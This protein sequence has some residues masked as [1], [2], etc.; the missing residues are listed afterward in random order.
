MGVFNIPITSY[1]HKFMSYLRS[2]IYIY[3]YNYDI[4]KGMETV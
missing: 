2:Y 3:M 4:Y 1:N